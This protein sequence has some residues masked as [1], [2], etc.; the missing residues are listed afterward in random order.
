MEGIGINSLN[1]KQFSSQRW[2]EDTI[3][4]LR[5]AWLVLKLYVTSCHCLLNWTK[6]I[7]AKM[8]AHILVQSGHKIF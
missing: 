3:V 6:I 4:S 5:Q 1:G 7:L 2:D 8:S